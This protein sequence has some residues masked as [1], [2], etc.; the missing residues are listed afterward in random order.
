MTE[1]E[2]LNWYETSKDSAFKRI[3]TRAIDDARRDLP[4][5]LTTPA[6]LP[7]GFD[8]VATLTSERAQNLR[9]ADCTQTAPAVEEAVTLA[10]LL[11]GAAPAPAPSA[12]VQGLDASRASRA[13]A[14]L[15]ADV[16]RMYEAEQRVITATVIHRA[17]VESLLR[18][19]LRCLATLDQTVR[20]NHRHAEYLTYLAPTDI[21]IPEDVYDIGLGRVR[22]A[23]TQF[24]RANG[25][26]QEVHEKE[27]IA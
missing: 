9:I 16:R 6:L 26:G 27:D 22:D 14:A 1:N 10:K 2:T 18:Y 12:G 8:E 19:G 17:S 13:S 11:T 21:S 15:A 5:V 7:R 23:L 25:R 4:N 24:D 20:A 3:L